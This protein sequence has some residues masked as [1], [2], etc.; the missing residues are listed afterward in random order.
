M[1]YW[2]ADSLRAGSGRN[3]ALI[4]LASHHWVACRRYPTEELMAVVIIQE[5][6]CFLLPLTCTSAYE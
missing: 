3:S 5:M 2:F 4:L 1:S 6:S